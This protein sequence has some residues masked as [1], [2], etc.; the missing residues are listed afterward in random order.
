M[1]ICLQGKIEAFEACEENRAIPQI[2]LGFDPAGGFPQ[3]AL[4]SIAMTA[5]LA[6]RALDHGQ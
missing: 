2:E 6:R 3:R 1:S 5:L 4:A